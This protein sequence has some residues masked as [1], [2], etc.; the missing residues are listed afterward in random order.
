MSSLFNIPADNIII[1][2]IILAGSF[3]LL[4]RSADFLVDG[5][6]A[7]AVLLRIPKIV[8]GIVLVGF[9]TTAPEFTVSLISALRGLPEI[10]LGNAVGSVIVDDAFAL[11]L[12]IIVAPVA[13]AVDSKILKRFGLFLVAIDIIA[14]ILAFNGTIDRWEG[15]VLLVI[16]VAYLLWV[17]LSEKKRRNAGKNALLDDEVE[18]HVKPGGVA[19]QFGRFFI[20]VAGVIVASDFLV[21]SAKNIA[22]IFMVSEAI[23]GLTIVAIG[24]SLPEI[25]TAI[26]A[27]R[28]GHGDLAL[29]D[30]LGADILN[31]LWIIGAASAAN[32]ITVSLNM[33]FFS[34]PAM[35]V[36]VGSMLVF[37]R[38]GYRFE[39]WKGIVLVSLYGIYLAAAIVIFFIFG[40]ES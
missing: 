13:I 31:M 4:A 38:L 37:A 1:N 21:E 34:F 25:A 17:F 23:I 39:R 19:L 10:A 36:I 12:G 20:G 30:I 24:T 8:I 35:F 6:V 3:Y 11:G 7:L 28:K 9:A 40:I 15:I 33:I 2:L 16:L 27:S 14:F 29:G 26:V 22:C 18:E 32:P 5:S